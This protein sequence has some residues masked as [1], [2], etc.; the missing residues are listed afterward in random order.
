MRLTEEYRTKKKEGVL[1]KLDFENAYDH[2]DGG[3]WIA[4]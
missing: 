2:V 3:F 4:K 1:L